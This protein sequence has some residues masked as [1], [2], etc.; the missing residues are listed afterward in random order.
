MLSIACFNTFHLLRSSPS[1]PPTPPGQHLTPPMR[2]TITLPA[3]ATAQVATLIIRTQCGWIVPP[4][5]RSK[6]SKEVTELRSDES[7]D[8]K[9]CKKQAN[10]STVF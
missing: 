6:K 2:N 5:Q 7:G 10:E 9:K 1:P 4:W 3:T 8:G